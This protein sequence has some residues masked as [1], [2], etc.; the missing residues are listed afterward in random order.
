[1]T[2]LEFKFTTRKNRSLLD[3]ITTYIS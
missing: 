2:S 1:L 3:C